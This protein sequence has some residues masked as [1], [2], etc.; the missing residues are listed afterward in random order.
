MTPPSCSSRA[1]PVLPGARRA[2]RRPDSSACRSPAMWSDLGDRWATRPGRGLSCVRGGADEAVLVR[3]DG[4]V[5][6][7]AVRAADD[8]SSQLAAAFRRVLSRGLGKDRGRDRAACWRARPG[9]HESRQQNTPA[10]RSDARSRQPEEGGPSALSSRPQLNDPL[11]AVSEK[12]RVVVGPAEGVS[13]QAYFSPRLRWLLRAFGMGTERTWV[14]V[15][16]TEV[17]VR[18]G[19]LRTAVLLDHVAAVSECP[20]PW[21]AQAGVHAGSSLPRSSS[22]S[23]PG[24]ARARG[25]PAWAAHPGRP[26]SASH[27]RRNRGM[28]CAHPPCRASRVRHP[29]DRPWLSRGRLPWRSSG[30]RRSASRACGGRCT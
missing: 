4:H 7:R 28:V 14:S 22:G 2:K 16:P 3:A 25:T 13:E 10:V 1:D 15:T 17:R 6:W 24:A 21:W 27:H 29:G 5:A 20:A 23:R 9:A 30:T 19:G 8:P 18:A 26:R 11:G 12:R